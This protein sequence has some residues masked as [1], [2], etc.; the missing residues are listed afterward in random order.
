MLR[1]ISFGSGSCGNCYYL[2]NEDY[3]L[4]IDLGI[5]VRKLKQYFTDYGLK[6]NHIQSVLITH[7]H[8]DHV[9]S[10]GSLCN[11]FNIPAY[12]TAEVHEGI[13]RNYV[14]RKKIGA[15]HVR[16]ITKNEAFTLGPFN[17]KAFS[18]PHDSLDNA[19][20][21]IQFGETVFCLMTDAGH[22]TEEM[23]EYIS[24]ADY[25]VIEANH[26]DEM[27]RCGPYPNHLKARVS[28]PRGHLSNSL[29][30]KS[31]TDNAS[32]RLKHVWLCHLSQENN[33]PELARKTVEQA[34]LSAENFD[35]TK[36]KLDVLRR[37]MPSGVFDLE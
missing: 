18:V 36:V 35:G 31:L 4:L 20:Y 13:R 27:L 23:A 8:A 32:S 30:A 29:C 28:G 6:F 10:I 34:L 12:A 7:D 25:L 16:T 5:S 2:Y 24:E 15:E 26:D 14:V 11:T 22:V 3:G 17:I 9:K 1:F 33:H 21:R 19:G 37:N